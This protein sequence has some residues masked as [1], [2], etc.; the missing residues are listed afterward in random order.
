VL[1]TARK[2]HELG[3]SDRYLDEVVAVLNGMDVPVL[4]GA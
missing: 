1:E 3:I 2:L 4:A